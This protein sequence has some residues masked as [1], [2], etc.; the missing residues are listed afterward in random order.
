M[1][2]RPINNTDSNRLKWVEQL[3]Y[4][5]DE[6]FRF[7]GTNFRFGVDPLLN[8]IP[9]AG[10]FTGLI[11]SAAL[12]LTMARHGASGRIVVLMAINIFLDATIGSIP[13][14]GQIFDFFY[15]ANKKNIRLLREHYYEGKH[16]GSGKNILVFVVLLFLVLFALF[17]YLAFELIVWVISWF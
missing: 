7:P 15:K 16:A 4:L 13:L 5:M 12:V 3:T 14:I 9:G 1:K 2:H 6:Q 10:G 11:I 17:V 8:L